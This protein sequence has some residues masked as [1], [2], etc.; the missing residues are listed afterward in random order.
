MFSVLF[1]V[2]QGQPGTIKVGVPGLHR[3]TLIP[4]TSG[5]LGEW[6]TPIGWT[7]EIAALAWRVPDPAHLRLKLGQTDVT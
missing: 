4:E 6:A 1:L 5:A 2:C 7:T 3:K